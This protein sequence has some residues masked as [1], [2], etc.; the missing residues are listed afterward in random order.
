MC[1]RDRGW[2]ADHL[3]PR[4]ALAVGAASGILAAG[5]AVYTMTRK[6]DRPKNI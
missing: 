6:L 5:V 3:G 4:W 2:V 1:I